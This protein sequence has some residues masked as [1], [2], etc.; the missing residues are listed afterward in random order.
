MRIYSFSAPKETAKQ[1]PLPGQL[2]PNGFIDAPIYGDIDALPE[3][4]A[5]RLVPAQLPCKKQGQNTTK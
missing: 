2:A 5:R 1:V 4:A 3:Q